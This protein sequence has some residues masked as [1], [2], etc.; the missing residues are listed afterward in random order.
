MDRRTV[1]RGALLGAPIVAAGTIAGTYLTT[2]HDGQRQVPATSATR[3]WLWDPFDSARGLPPALGVQFHGTWD[4][5]FEGPQSEVPLPMFE[6]HLDQLAAQDVAVLRLDVGWSTSQPTQETPSLTQWYN[7]RINR[8]LSAAAERDMEVFLTLHQS[9]DWSRPGTSGDARQFPTDPASIVPWAT[10]MAKTFGDRVLAWEVWNEP[11]LLGFTGISDARERPAKYVPLLK[12]TFEGLKAG[13]PDAVVVFGGPSKTD[14]AFIRACYELGAKPYFDVLSIHPYQGDQRVPPD[15]AD[16]D[17][18]GR[19]THFP[20]VVDVMSDYD[21]SKP[22]WWTEFGYSVHSNED[23][24]AGQPWRNGVASE[25]LSAEYFIR[26]FELARTAYPQVRLAVVYTAYKE[27]ADSYGHQFG[28][29]MMEADGTLLPQL[30]TLR[31]YVAAFGGS[32]PPLPDVSS[33][34][35]SP[36]PSPTTS[37]TAS[38][39]GSPTMSPTA[40]PSAPLTGSPTSSPTGPPTSSAAPTA[41]PS[42]MPSGSPPASVSSPVPSASPSGISSPPSPLA[43]PSG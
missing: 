27:S 17:T 30:P 43:T 10:W 7:A 32:R 11:N 18:A 4:I 8:V 9:P 39:G 13:D 22:V 34:S 40:S 29:R 19:M 12:A 24:P 33:P 23:V 26:A 31:G 16:Q 2:V 36:S 6:R 35:P 28:Y 15:S 3:T 38:P 41:H 21:D 5:Y 1:L 42:P 37:S 20:A 14:D 25:A